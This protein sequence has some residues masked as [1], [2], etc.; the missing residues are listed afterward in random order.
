VPARSAGRRCPRAR[1][2]GVAFLDFKQERFLRRAWDPQGAAT[3]S[4]PTQL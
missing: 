4:W 2:I 1:V 3:P